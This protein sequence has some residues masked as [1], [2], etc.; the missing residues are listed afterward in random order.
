MAAVYHEI[1][2][3]WGGETY[4]VTPTYATIQRIEQ[5][6]S[7]T[8]VIS[9]IAK[10]EPPVSQIA[11]IVQELL[12]QAGCKSANAEEIYADMMTDP[13]GKAFQRN[14]ML[15]MTAFVPQAETG[16]APAPEGAGATTSR[17]STGASITQ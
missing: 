1:E 9:R 13:K 17:K 3:E 7:I 2:L 15:V 14:A 10:G 11:D 4:R 5:R 6:I 12:R 16:N 8:S